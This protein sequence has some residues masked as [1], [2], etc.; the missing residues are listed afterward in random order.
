MT[1]PLDTANWTSPPML[2]ALAS[3]GVA[4]FVGLGSFIVR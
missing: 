1:A 4:V 2:A 3:V